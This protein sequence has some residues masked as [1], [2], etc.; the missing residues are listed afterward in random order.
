MN[1]D[2]F[3]RTCLIRAYIQHLTHFWLDILR[4]FLDVG[5]HDYASDGGILLKLQR[6]IER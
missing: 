6:F 4:L 5:E 1:K 2:V 3:K